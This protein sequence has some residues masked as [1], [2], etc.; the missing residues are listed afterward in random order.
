MGLFCVAWGQSLSQTVKE[1]RRVSIYAP[2]WS[3]NRRSASKGSYSGL[4][5]GGCNTKC[6]VA[7]VRNTMTQRR[8]YEAHNIEA[9]GNSN[10]HIHRKKH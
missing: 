1:A 4:Y 9:G 5:R 7:T 6:A 3:I 8:F 10:D 2:K